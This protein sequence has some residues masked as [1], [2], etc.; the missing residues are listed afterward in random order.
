[1]LGCM[2]RDWFLGFWLT[3]SDP[4]WSEI[5]LEQSLIGSRLSDGVL[6]CLGSTAF[7]F[8]RF[9]KD[10]RLN[11]RMDDFSNTTQNWSD[12]FQDHLK[13]M[14]SSPEPRG[15]DPEIILYHQ[16]AQSTV[17]KSYR[18][19]L[20]KTNLIFVFRTRKVISV[21]CFLSLVSSLDSRDF[22]SRSCFCSW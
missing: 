22:R 19:P 11:S 3:H 16:S 17:S 10:S 6:P 1:M 4:K 14:K 21:A 18:P 13:Y 2:H 7:H 12:T 15:I 9:G 5:T 20:S 8:D